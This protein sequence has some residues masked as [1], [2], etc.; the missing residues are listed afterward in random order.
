MRRIQAAAV[1]RRAVNTYQPRHA[2]HAEPAE[3][4]A[5]LRGLADQIQIVPSKN[6]SE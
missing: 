5:I 1:R 3:L 2:R 4:P 6:D